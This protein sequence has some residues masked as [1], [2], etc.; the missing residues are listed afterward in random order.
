MGDQRKSFGIHKV[1]DFQGGGLSGNHLVSSEELCDVEWNFF[2]SKKKFQVTN[3][4]IWRCMYFVSDPF[5]S[6]PYN[7]KEALLKYDGN[8]RPYKQQSSCS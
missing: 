4:L 6:S 3:R 2:F 8:S 7:R 5:P 1:L